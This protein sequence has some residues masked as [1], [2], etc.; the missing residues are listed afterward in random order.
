[1]NSKTLRLAITVSQTTRER[2]QMFLAKAKKLL[3][4]VC[5]GTTIGFEHKTRRLTVTGIRNLDGLRLTKVAVVSLAVGMDV[6]LRN[7]DFDLHHT[8]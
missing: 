4:M 6:I 7:Y 5:P 2:N 3:A 1:M 8:A